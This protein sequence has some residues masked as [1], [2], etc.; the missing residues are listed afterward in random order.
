MKKELLFVF[1]LLLS[2]FSA[3]AITV[4]TTQAEPSDQAW[5]AQHD[6][7]EGECLYAGVVGEMN[8]A[9]AVASLLR[10][11]EQNVD[12]LVRK[13]ALVLLGQIY[14]YGGYGVT[15]DFVAAY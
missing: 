6:L 13:K 15:Q 3:C 5:R 8:Y 1:C 10:A 7:Y 2:I 14:Y 12:L 11:A 9:G 4:P